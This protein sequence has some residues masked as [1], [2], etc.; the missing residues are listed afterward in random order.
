[1]QNEPA[2]AILWWRQNDLGLVWNEVCVVMMPSCLMGAGQAIA[3]SEHDNGR[4]GDDGSHQH[5]V[6]PLSPR[7]AFH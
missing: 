5:V 1:M 7:I 2:A 4:K 3:D 6:C